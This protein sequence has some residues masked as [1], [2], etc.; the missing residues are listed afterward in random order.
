MKKKNV[1]KV[2]TLTE[3]DI[4]NNHIVKSSKS[5]LIVIGIF[6][7]S[8][9]LII[10]GTFFRTSVNPDYPLVFTDSN[11]NLMYITKSNNTKNDIVS[12]A[13]AK[14]IYANNDTRYLLYVNN[15]ALY[16]LDTTVGGE[17]TKIAD[18]PID[19][20]FSA[21]DDYIYY[22]DNTN[23]LNIY[24][25]KDEK[26]KTIDDKVTKV[27][28]AN[29]KYTLYS[30]D[31]VLYIGDLTEDENYKV[32]NEYQKVEINKA[33]KLVLYSVKSSVG[34]DYYL[35]NIAL[36]SNIKVLTNVNKIYAKNSDYTKFIYTKSVTVSQNLA[37][38]TKSESGSKTLSTKEND[39]LSKFS[40]EANSIYYMNKDVETTLATD[41]NNLYIVDMDNLKL[42]YSKYDF[43]NTSINLDDYDGLSDLE[44]NVKKSFNNAIYYQV[45]SN[46]ANKVY[47]NFSGTVKAYFRGND[48]LYLTEDK[49][50]VISLYYAKLSNKTA[51]S[52][53][54]VDTNLVTDKIIEKYTNGYIYFVNKDN[55]QN[56]MVISAG[57]AKKISD[58]VNNAILEVLEN[59]E[60][61]YYL[62]DSDG[63]NGTLMLYNGIRVSKVMDNVHSMVYI[64]DD[65][66]YLTVNY[67]NT[68]ETCDL[69]RLDNNK[70]TLI[71]QGIKNWFN[72]IEKSKTEETEN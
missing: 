45:D 20:G 12:S 51:K 11:S 57:S 28:I 16:L 6:I 14:I 15:N 58:N 29:A 27:E 63:Y 42:V 62:K 33:N 13:D 40:Y 49:N 60:S 32:N 54:L 5:Y 34:Y 43:T 55:S 19:Y 46:D 21:E 39:Y 69:Y 53:T 17:G 25:R 10:I 36:N 70:T 52:A 31:G 50:E 47:N 24:N 35:Y 37:N 59:G 48:E 61:F 8:I 38:I 3:E 65:L 4:K 23:K 68:M 64:N 56:L 67:N 18:A 9:A 71:Y 44:E 1:E 30:K 7:L 41:I 66:I 26:I 22:V 72:P 2:Q